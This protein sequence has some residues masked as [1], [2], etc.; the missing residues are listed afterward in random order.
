MTVATIVTRVTTTMIKTTCY[1]VEG[2]GF[3]PFELDEEPPY[4]QEE[5]KEG[6]MVSKEGRKE[7]KRV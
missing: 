4:V 6:M 2:D 7:G 1:D 5:R 3:C